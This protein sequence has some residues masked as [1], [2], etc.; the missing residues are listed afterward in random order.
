MNQLKKSRSENQ[1]EKGLGENKGLDGLRSNI[2]S[3]GKSFVK[4][5]KKNV[6]RK[7]CLETTTNEVFWSHNSNRSPLFS[8]NS[9]SPAS[10]IGSSSSASSQQSS[11]AR[12][13]MDTIQPAVSLDQHLRRIKPAKKKMKCAYMIPTL[14][15]CVLMVCLFALIWGKAFAVVTCTSAWLFFAPSRR[16]PKLRRAG[17]Y[18]V[19]DSEEYKKRVMMEGWLERDRTRVLQY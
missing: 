8:S 4:S 13:E 12:S 9:S 16:S 18:E 17:S 2:L 5:M 19:M 11:P 14:E 1:H 10:S 15:I 6:A 7:Q 3:R